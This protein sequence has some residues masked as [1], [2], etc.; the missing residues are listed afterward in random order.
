MYV[1]IIFNRWDEGDI[2]A[3]LGPYSHQEAQD[4]RYELFGDKFRRTS[5]QPVLDEIPEW[6]M[7]SDK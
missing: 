2:D 7:Y 5:I 1:L 4:K 6:S 3:V